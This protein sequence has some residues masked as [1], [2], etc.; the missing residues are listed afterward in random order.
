MRKFVRNYIENVK[1]RKKLADEYVAQSSKF[2]QYYLR[3]GQVL[4]IIS[5]T[6]F[7]QDFARHPD[8][9]AE[10]FKR[11]VAKFERLAYKAFK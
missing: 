11:T 8:H 3:F 4:A 6:Y 1:R 2:F 10:S 9:V 7:A 5:L